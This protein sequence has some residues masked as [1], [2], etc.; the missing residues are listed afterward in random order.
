MLTIPSTDSFV[1]RTRTIE[2]GIF[3]HF[4]KQSQ[5]TGFV[6]PKPARKRVVT[7]TCRLRRRGRLPDQ[8]DLC[9]LSVQDAAW[10]E[11]KNVKTASLFPAPEAG[12]DQPAQRG[13]CV[14]SN[15]YDTTKHKGLRPRPAADWLPHQA[16]QAGLG[17]WRQ[18]ERHFHLGWFRLQLNLR[19]TGR[20]RNSAIYHASEARDQVALL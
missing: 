7:K 12:N 17:S 15:Y 6:G 10:P 16:W 4:P 8:R 20:L 1:V 5:R 2:L 13:S 19:P 3:K 14:M 11:A 18:A 9:H